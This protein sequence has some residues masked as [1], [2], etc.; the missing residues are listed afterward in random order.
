MRSIHRDPTPGTSA[1]FEDENVANVGLVASD[2]IELVI[3]ILSLR[4]S[5]VHFCQFKITH[6][7]IGQ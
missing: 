5:H 7:G 3:L 1:I 6:V 4:T 2:F